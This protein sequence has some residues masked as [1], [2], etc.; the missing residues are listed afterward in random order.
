MPTQHNTNPL[1]FELFRLLSGAR[2]L[3]SF[4]VT[5]RL[6]FSKDNSS[7]GCLVARRSLWYIFSSS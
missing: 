1:E 3:F 2:R 7:S 4:F 5:L 6:Y